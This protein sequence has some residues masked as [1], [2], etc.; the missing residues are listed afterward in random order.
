MKPFSEQPGTAQENGV[1]SSQDLRF[2]VAANMPDIGWETT[3][4]HG[5]S[6]T[7]QSLVSTWKLT[8]VRC[9]S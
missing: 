2:L 9:K 5:T 3:K 6:F 4:H 1:W 8:V 7:S